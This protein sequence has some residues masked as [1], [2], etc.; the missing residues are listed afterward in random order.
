VARLQAPA[1]DPDRIP[2]KDMLELTV[3][4]LLGLYRNREF[5]RVGYYVVNSLENAQLGPDGQPV[6]PD[7]EVPTCVPTRR[8]PAD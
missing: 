8:P 2:K 7:L 1:P 4:L 3:I 6:V 5:I